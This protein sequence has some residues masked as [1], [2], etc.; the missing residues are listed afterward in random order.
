MNYDMKTNP[1]RE[2][3][4]AVMKLKKL[5]GGY[6]GIA[7]EIGIGHRR[8]MQLHRSIRN[9]LPLTMHALTETA[10]RNFLDKHKK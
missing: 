1:Q 9:N 8:L 7:K 10:F 6:L 3:V 4:K 5:K 2:L